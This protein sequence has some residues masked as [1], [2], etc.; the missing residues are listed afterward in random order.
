MTIYIIIACWLRCTSTSAVVDNSA[1]LYTKEEFCR[2]WSTA[3]SEP[4]L[5]YSNEVRGYEV[6]LASG[7]IR[8]VEC[9]VTT[10]QDLRD[11]KE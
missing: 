8:R 9:S 1:T 6:N 4:R 11:V 5:P 3:H 2:L 7:T 10:V